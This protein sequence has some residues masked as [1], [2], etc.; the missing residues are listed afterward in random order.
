MAN[1][2]WVGGGSSTNWAATSNTN[3]ATT[4]GGANNASVPT[5]A[6]AVIFDGVG[7]S[8]NGTSVIGAIITVLSVTITSGFTGT[9]NHSQALTIAGNLTL[10]ANY[11]ITGAGN[12]SISANAVLTSNG[13]TWPNALS[14]TGG[15][16]K[17]FADSWNILGS[18]NVATPSTVTINSVLTSATIS[19]T[20]TTAATFTGTAGWICTA[21]GANQ[22]AAATI[23]LQDGIEYIINGSL[24]SSASRVGTPVLFTSSHATNKAKL[25]L[26]QDATCITNAFFTR[27]DA[28]LGR[29]INTWTG[30]VTDCVNINRFT[31]LKTVAATF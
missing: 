2:Y 27:I 23:T 20:S 14:F 7:A 12:I 21:F 16:T 28:S 24:A 19:T 15:T 4:S 13:K 1:R 22:T 5:S 10:G 31:D 8:A 30:T 11:T 3:W 9:I 17:T 29:S 25:T 26:D 18:F 6:D